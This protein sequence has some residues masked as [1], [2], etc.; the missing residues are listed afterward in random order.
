MVGG[1]I[2]GGVWTECLCGW[3]MTLKCCKN[4]KATDQKSQPLFNQYNKPRNGRTKLGRER[5]KIPK[6]SPKIK[7]KQ[8]TKQEPLNCSQYF[9]KSIKYIEI[10]FQNMCKIYTLETI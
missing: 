1:E 8:K 9:I 7:K 2:L 3:R 6:E 4:N 5:I 10:F